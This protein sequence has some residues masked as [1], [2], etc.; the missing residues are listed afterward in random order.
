MDLHPKK[1]GCLQR[2]LTIDELAEQLNVKKSWVYDNWRRAGIPAR[3]IGNQLR[4]RSA[5]VDRWIDRQLDDF[6]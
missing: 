6:A 1:G 4:F 5:D 2:L 3:R